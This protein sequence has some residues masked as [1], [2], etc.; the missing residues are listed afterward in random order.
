MRL[1]PSLHAAARRTRPAF[2]RSTS[3]P[4]R[5]SVATKDR[6]RHGCGSPF[7]TILH[8]NSKDRYIRLGD[9]RLQ[10]LS[11]NRLGPDD[12]GRLFGIGGAGL[13]WS[14]IA[15]DNVPDSEVGSLRNV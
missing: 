1:I 10:D 7:R 13:P 8:T 4:R 2:H 9:P 12:T 6:L 5:P 15:S 14:Q 11:L 3:E